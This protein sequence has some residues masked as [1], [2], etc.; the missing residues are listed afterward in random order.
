M[1]IPIILSG[2][3]GTRLWPLSRG[4]YP[5]QFLPLA[6]KKSLFQETLLRVSDRNFFSEPI[7]IC[8]EAHRFIAGF[9]STEIGINSFRI[10][11]EPT[12]KNTA[13][14][15]TASVLSNNQHSDEDIFLVVSSDHLIENRSEFRSA[16][17]KGAQICINDLIVIFGTEPSEP[18]TNYGYIKYSHDSKNRLVFEGFTEKPIFEKA[19]EF[20]EE[21]NYLW[22][23]G[24]FMFKKRT[25]INEIKSLSPEMYDFAKASVDNAK[26]DLDFLR[27][28]ASNF[29]N[30]PNISID[31]ALLEKTR[32]IG[33]VN[34]KTSWSDLGTWQSVFQS[35]QKDDNNNVIEG[36]VLKYDSSESLIISEEKLTVVSG[37]KDLIV[38]NTSDVTLIATKSSY[39]KTMVNL[40]L[41]DLSK[42]NRNEKTDNQKCHRPWGW[43]ES[44][45]KH[46][47]FQV[48]RLHI[49]PKSKLS[50]QFHKFRSEHWVVVKGVAEVIKGKNIYRLEK[51]DSVFINT[52][53]THSI[54]NERDEE[55]VVIEVQSGS[56][57]GED[58]IVRLEDIYGRTRSKD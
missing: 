19:K 49:N 50:L 6:S 21:K 26:E 22:N 45:L 35:K 27:L 56:Y 12:S 46:Q 33:L 30:C 2:G 15:I 47:T 36:D 55:L 5:K 43:Y 51:G 28:D 52:G 40:I 20:F 44:I 42:L 18:N 9:Q 32:K 11:V 37:V 7:I 31:Y 39:D 16:V 24:I 25:F 41:S 1:I 8:N 3:S 4:S 10:I 48:K 38:V 57:L 34:L 54:S 17:E 23:C 58:D 53:E 14:A 13:P 29:S